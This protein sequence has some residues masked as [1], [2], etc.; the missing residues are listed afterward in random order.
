MCVM[1]NFTHVLCPFDFFPASLRAASYAAALAQNYGAKLDLLH[2]CSPASSKNKDDLAA[3]AA[4]L[5]ADVGT[6]IR[7][8]YV[9]REIRRAM[10]DH[11]T[12]LLVMGTHG[13]HGLE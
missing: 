7:S 2:V 3:A 4:A 1:L 5:G 11:H 12:D 8:G 10:S 6:E 9:V 13:R